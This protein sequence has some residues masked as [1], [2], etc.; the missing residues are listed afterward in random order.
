MAG[1]IIVFPK[2]EDGKSIRN[3]LIRHG[4]DV[5]AVCT[6]G[7]QALSAT[8]LMSDGLVISGYKFSDMNYFD[9]HAL[10]PQGFDML[11]L[12]SSKVCQECSVPGILCVNMPLKVQE[13]MSTVEMMYGNLVRRRKKQRAKPKARSEEEQQ[14][15]WEAKK[16]LMERNHMSEEEAHRYIQKCSMDSGTSLTETAQMVLISY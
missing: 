16:I 5:S 12:A 8:D 15:L 6:L 9:L 11:L 7:A 1:I 2:A 3:L 14:I 4:Y 10:L 13:L